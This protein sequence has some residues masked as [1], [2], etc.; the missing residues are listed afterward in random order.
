MRILLFLAAGSVIAIASCGGSNDALDGP[1]GAGAAGAA[2]STAGGAA[3]TSG[4]GGT[5]GSGVGGEPVDAGGAGGDG[6]YP[7]V[8][9][10]KTAEQACKTYVGAY[11]SQLDKCSPI[12][13]QLL[14]KDAADCEARLVPVCVKALGLSDTAKTPE[15]TAACGDAVA[16]LDCSSLLTRKIPAA[17]T[18]PAGPRAQ[19]AVCGEDGQCATGY[20]ATPLDQACGTCKNRA[21]DS[22]PCTRDDDCAYELTCA[23]NLV[24]TPFVAKAG[25]CDDNHPC[26]PGL[27]CQGVVGP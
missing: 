6:S 1:G 17:C 12:Y 10:N 15:S 5:A 19:D 21:A 9:P 23:K 8:P 4:A 18:P 20:C 26:A 24:C 22:Q 7:D 11:C 14:W 25:E 13:L 27:S 16:A 3:G 2:G